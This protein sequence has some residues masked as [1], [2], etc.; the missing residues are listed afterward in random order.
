MAGL[1]QRG[2][3]VGSRKRGYLLFL[4]FIAPNFLFLLVFTY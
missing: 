3:Q 2:A 4:A 1:A